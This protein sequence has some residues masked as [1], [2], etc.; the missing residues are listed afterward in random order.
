MKTYIR[1]LLTALLLLCTAAVQ[2]QIAGGSCGTNLTWTLSEDSTLTISGSGSMPNYTSTTMP[3][4]DHLAAI[5]KVVVEEGI[6]NLGNYAF[7]NCSSLV[8]ATL[9]E[10]VTTIGAYAF[11]YCTSLAKVNIPVSVSTIGRYAFYNCN[12]MQEIIFPAGLT[13]IGNYTFYQCKSLEKV[14]SLATTA[15]TLGDKAFA[16]IPAT[17]PITV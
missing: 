5:K 16:Q 17:A 13:A 12:K 9:A 7:R 3:W 10:S 8:E 11:S 4:K 6:T 15:P 1:H 2:A 14:T